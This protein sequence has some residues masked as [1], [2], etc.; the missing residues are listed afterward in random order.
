M[1]ANTQKILWWMAILFGFL[2]IV[3]FGAVLITSGRA[4]PH[5]AEVAAYAAVASAAAFSIEILLSLLKEGRSIMESEVGIA[6][7]REVL[8]E[9]FQVDEARLCSKREMPCTCWSFCGGDPDM[10][11]DSNADKLPVKVVPLK[12]INILGEKAKFEADSLPIL[13]RNHVTDCPFP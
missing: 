9:R 8:N 6:N 7:R 13:D 4:L 2:A 11:T 3:S 5:L 1:A 10:H 12:H